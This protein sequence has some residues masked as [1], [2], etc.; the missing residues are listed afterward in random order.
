MQEKHW[1]APKNLLCEPIKMFYSHRYKS[2]IMLF[3]PHLYVKLHTWLLLLSIK[4]KKISRCRQKGGREVQRE[5]PNN[6]WKKNKTFSW[7]LGTMLGVP[8]WKLFWSSNN[9]LSNYMWI[10]LKVS[11]ICQKW[12]KFFIDSGSE[13]NELQRGMVGFLFLSSVR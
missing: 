10:E 13:F 2:I 8:Y 9:D 1:E 11:L 6:G 12:K 4:F 7:K 5:R 3:I